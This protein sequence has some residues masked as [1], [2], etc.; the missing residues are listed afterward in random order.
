[1]SLIFNTLFLIFVVVLFF[2]LRERIAL[3]GLSNLSIE[4]ISLKGIH[5]IRYQGAPGLPF[6]FTSSRLSLRLHFPTTSNPRWLTIEADT[7]LYKSDTCD[8]FVGSLI[9]T[10]W[11]LPRLFKQ[12]AGPWADIKADDVRIR[13]T[14]SDAI[15]HCIQMLR[16]NIVD[17]VLTGEILRV[18]DFST[19]V[20]FAG[21][22]EAEVVQH[23]DI[24]KTMPESGRY[25][26]VLNGH[27]RVVHDTL[28]NN[29]GSM[30][31][32]ASWDERKRKQPTSFISKDQDEM[33]ISAVA[34]GLHIHNREGRFYSFASVN[35]QHRRN[36][37]ANRGTFVLIA[38][39]CRWVKLPRSNE[40]DAPRSWALWVSL[41]AICHT[42]A[43][44]R[45]CQPAI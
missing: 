32:I 41:L 22:S 24:Y 27:R 20:R 12:T 11:F 31:S 37:T 33:R 26:D 36:W 2:L 35:A 4:T 9:I 43:D 21:L 6:N 1:M 30:K 3:L 29:D 15:P 38:T 19:T 44:S 17:A 39:E 42:I 40:M 25:N 28:T 7:I 45:V 34:E 8:V 18:D 13:V 10:C 5:G 16:A 14:S 23:E